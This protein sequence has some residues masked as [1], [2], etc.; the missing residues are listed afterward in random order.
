MGRVAPTS[1]G[2]EREGKKYAPLSPMLTTAEAAKILHI[3][4]NTLRRWNNQ[5]II[6]S[7][8]IGPRSDRRFKQED[9]I[10]LLG[11]VRSPKKIIRDGQ[12]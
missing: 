11:E 9:V 4:G 12:N 1:R 6:M 2:K 10:A 3:H 8:R 5:G 7:Y